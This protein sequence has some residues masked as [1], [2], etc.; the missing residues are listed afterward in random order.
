MIIALRTSERVGEVDNDNE[1][2]GDE[3]YADEV[4]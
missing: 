2:V 1:A 4:I 3:E